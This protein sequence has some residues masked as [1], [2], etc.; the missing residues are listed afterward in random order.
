MS[1]FVAYAALAT[2]LSSAAPL[3]AQASDPAVGPVQTLDD[4][5]LAT[6]KAGG[7]AARAARIAPVVDQAYDVPLLTRLSVG[8][9]W[10]TIAPADQTALVAALRRLT[11]AQYASNFDRFSGQSFAIDPRVETRGTD[12]LVRTTLRQPKGDSVSIGYRLRQSG[13]R[14]KIVDV[15]YNNAVSQ[16]AT[17]RADF[18]TAFARGGAKALIAHLDALTAKA[19]R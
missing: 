13:G 16:L 18:E 2:A 10:T 7:Y 19:T 15:Y 11:I 1:R 14:W 17:R 8:T 12:K 5:L 6:L 3:A 4:G 9:G